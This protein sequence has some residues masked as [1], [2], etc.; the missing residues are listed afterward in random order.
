MF[1]KLAP[2]TVTLVSGLFIIK[3]AYTRFF[4]LNFTEKSSE[5]TEY[6]SNNQRKRKSTFC[7]EF[8]ATLAE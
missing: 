8:L 7:F 4:I 5:K 1:N 2:K 3:P 6:F